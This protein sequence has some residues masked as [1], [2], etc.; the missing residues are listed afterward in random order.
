MIIMNSVC[1]DISNLVL[2]F[3]ATQIIGS[4]EYHFSKRYFVRNSLTVISEIVQLT[5]FVIADTE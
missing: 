4:T 2:H 5:L 1:R 3:K